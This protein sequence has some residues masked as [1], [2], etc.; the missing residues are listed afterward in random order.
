LKADEDMSVIQPNRETRRDFFS[1]VSDGLV[2]TALAGLLSRDVLGR[3]AERATHDVLSKRSPID[4][5]AKAVIQLFMTGGPSQ[6][7]LFDPKPTLEKYA[8]QLPRELLD[9][10]ESVGAARGLLPSP[11]KF[12]QHGASGME[13]SELMPHLAESADDIAVIRS[14]YTTSFSHESAVF[15]MHSGRTFTDGPSLGSWVVY[16]L[17]SDNENLPAYVALDDPGKQIL[18]GVQN[19]QSGW[20]PPVYQ[21]TRLRTVGQ[22]I[23]NLHP[24]REFPGAV[25]KLSRSLL[26]RIA[27][28][29]RDKRPHQQDLDARIASYELSARMQLAATDALDISKEDEPTRE[30]YGV[31]DAT[32]SSYARRCL[33][34]RR[35]VERGVRIVQIYMNTDSS[36][37]PWDHHG[38]LKGSLPKSCAATDRPVGALLKDLKQ[39]GLLEST[40][41][42]W[43]GEFGR[44]PL[45]QGG[46]RPGRDHGANGFSVW[47]AG[48]GV[49]G[50]T[51]YG[52][53]DEFGYA[54]VE[55]R[56]SVPMYHATILRLL[57]LD[58]EKLVYNHHGLDE[59]LTGVEPVE[60]VSE[61]IA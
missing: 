25:S 31:N 47:L 42:V 38:D 56:V 2:G 51:V 44:L 39:R 30:L 35:L 15:L 34:A 17:G 57:G 21:G 45:A 20:L 11:F 36:D 26:Q 10:V 14:M 46:N 22:P 29:H 49:N 3:P 54:A 48:G 6:V 28:E 23:I 27:A 33:M 19:W 18:L 53:T 9:G 61:L 7:D 24:E 58:H 40:L 50:G 1:R 59:R 37:N 8:N 12:G 4:V 32:T 60:Y 13:I 52:A 55:N 5:P 16:G 41:I 43:G